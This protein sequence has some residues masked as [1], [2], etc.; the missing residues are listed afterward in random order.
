MDRLQF[1]KSIEFPLDNDF[2]KCAIEYFD[3]E[4]LL[5]NLVGNCKNVCII[6]GDSLSPSEMVFSVAF[7][8]RDDAKEMIGILSGSSDVFLYGK[9]FHVISSIP[10]TDNNAVEIRLQ[11]FNS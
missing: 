3:H 4:M 1:V 11:K 10:I 5:Y 9:R 2:V 6:K 7:T 8:N